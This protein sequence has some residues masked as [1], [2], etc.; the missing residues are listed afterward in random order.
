M[1]L[2][3]GVP[4]GSWFGRAT[5]IRGF[6]E[7]CR[8]APEQAH[9]KNFL[10]QTQRR[11]DALIVSMGRQ[12]ASP[13]CPCGSE[14]VTQHVL[15]RRRVRSVCAR[16]AIRATPLRMRLMCKPAALQ[17]ALSVPPTPLGRFWVSRSA[18]RQRPQIAYLLPDPPKKL[19]YGTPGSLIR[20]C[21][22]S[23][24]QAHTHD[25]APENTHP[26]CREEEESQ[27]YATRRGRRGHSRKRSPLSLHAGKNQ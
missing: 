13:K 10:A 8:P 14:T 2:C 21:F 16:S 18:R 23:K 27:S 26:G 3:A 15:R 19:T 17:K 6:S 9:L 24:Q 25:H 4:T 20:Q 1:A 7:G 5:R 12:H 11:T 22:W